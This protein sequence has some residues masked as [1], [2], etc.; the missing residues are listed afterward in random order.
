VKEESERL[1][2]SFQ[3]SDIKKGPSSKLVDFK[4][5][6][7]SPPSEKKAVP[8]R[9][10]DEEDEDIDRDFLFGDFKPGTFDYEKN[11]DPLS[12]FGSS[13]SNPL[14]ELRDTINQS[15][16]T[17]QEK[18]G[19]PFQQSQSTNFHPSKSDK[20]GFSRIKSS[21]SEFKTELKDYELLSDAKHGGKNSGMRS[22]YKVLNSNNLKSFKENFKK[23]TF[24]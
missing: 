16:R 6:D 14:H 24:S 17:S 22:E 21:F 4:F 20:D 9:D 1:Q 19:K 10:N 15:R 18:F 7:L 8:K 23:I 2:K 3:K 11:E 12:G 13:K 5:E